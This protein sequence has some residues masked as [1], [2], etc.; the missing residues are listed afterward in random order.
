MTPPDLEERPGVPTDPAC[1]RAL[2]ERDLTGSHPDIWRIRAASTRVL[3]AQIAL[4]PGELV[5]DLG[6]GNGWLS[7][8][9][10]SAGSR[11]LAVDLSNDGLDGLGA[12]VTAGI[13]AT[14]VQGDSAPAVRGR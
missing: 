6:A 10:A 2:P 5:L 4:W 14:L 3:F 1:V 8:R 12:A 11:V 7:H 13:A 9:L